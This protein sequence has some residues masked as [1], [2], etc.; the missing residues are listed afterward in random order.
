MA[1]NKDRTVYVK[2]PVEGTIKIQTQESTKDEVRSDLRKTLQRG[3][4][5]GEGKVVIELTE[6]KE[7]K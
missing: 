3:F 4:R 7:K 5:C 6:Q 1:I 2:L